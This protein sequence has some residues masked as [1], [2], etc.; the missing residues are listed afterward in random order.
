M[1]TA[2]SIAADAAKLASELPGEVLDTAAEVLLGAADLDEARRSVAERVAHA[3]YRRSIDGFLVKCEK[4]A[5]L[6]PSAIAVALLTAAA[7]ERTHRMSRE[8][9]V[10]WTGPDS[11]TVPFRQTEQVILQILDSA[12]QRITLVSYAVYAIPRIREALV[13]AAARGVQITVVLETPDRISSENEYSTLR[14]M[15]PEV[16][17]CSRVYYWPMEKRPKVGQ[18]VGILHVKCV[19]ADGR[20]LFVTSANLTDYAF[21][22]NMELGVLLTGGSLPNE[23]SALFDDL[24]ASGTLARI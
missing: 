9:E 6:A 14:A 12:K 24:I 11:E 23:T 5:R 2:R 22:I 20:W 7:S 15:G 17:S 8:V 18:K 16:A 1:K 21:S 19:V 10:V 3:P 13:R 4:D